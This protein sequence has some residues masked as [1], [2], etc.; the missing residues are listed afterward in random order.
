MTE[1]TSVYDSH[2]VA[3]RLLDDSIARIRRRVATQGELE[4]L[5]PI[6]LTVIERALDRDL[7][8]IGRYIQYH[9]K[10]RRNPS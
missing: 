1:P 2:A 6:V 4:T 10:T 9:F 3:R 7:A 5:P 8:E